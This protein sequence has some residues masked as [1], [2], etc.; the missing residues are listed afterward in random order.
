ML[1]FHESGGP[2]AGG[3]RGKT[4]TDA[5]LGSV[6]E[7][8]GVASEVVAHAAVINS[9]ITSWF[10]AAVVLC[11]PPSSRWSCPSSF[12][13]LLCLAAALSLHGLIN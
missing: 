9:F 3:P 13:C 7:K 10:H 6:G 2:R 4:L 5:T 1:R 11:T 8:S 12:A